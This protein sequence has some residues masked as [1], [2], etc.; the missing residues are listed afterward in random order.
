MAIGA[1]P[2]APPN[3]M[4]RELPSPPS[5]IAR[6]IVTTKIQPAVQAEGHG[7]LEARDSP[8]GSKL[9]QRG[10]GGQNPNPFDGPVAPAKPLWNVWYLDLCGK[11][12]S[13]N[14]SNSVRVRKK[15]QNTA[16]QENN[17]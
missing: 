1:I 3:K 2:G 10:S 17:K 4:K 12:K 7:S 14:I 16:N 6:S 9:S 13:A 11:W 8:V 15:A 5:R